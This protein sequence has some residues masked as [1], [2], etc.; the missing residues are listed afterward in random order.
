MHNFDD[1]AEYVQNSNEFKVKKLAAIKDYSAVKGPEGTSLSALLL[2]M[3]DNILNC[4][5]EYLRAY[6]DWLQENPIQQKE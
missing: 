6:D 2:T 3:Q 4:V 5:L 1:F